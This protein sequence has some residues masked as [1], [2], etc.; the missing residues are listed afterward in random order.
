MHMTVPQMWPLI[1]ADALAGRD[2]ELAR[3]RE[4]AARARTDGDALLV[5]GDAGVG[6][7]RLLDAAAQAAAADGWR[8]LRADGAEFEAGLPYSGLSQAL[9]PLLG[10][11][12]ELTAAHRDAL[13]IALGLSQGRSPDR[14]VVSM[15]TL[16]LLR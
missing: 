12:S 2:A 5:L 4:F 8:V 11:F 14:L 13:S 15:A 6:K 3:L 10:Q 16:T 1:G 7:T 9:P